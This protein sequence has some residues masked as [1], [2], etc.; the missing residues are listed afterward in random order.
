MGDI[1]VNLADKHHRSRSSHQ[2]AVSV[3]EAIEAIGRRYGA[4]TKV[5]EVPPGPPVMAPIVAEIYGP[6]EAGRIAVARGVKQVF[7]GTRD[8]VAIDDSIDEDAPKVVLHVLQAKAA[9]LGVAQSDI[10]EV[11]AMGLAGQ[12][13]TPARNTSSKFEIPV[14]VT[15][16]AEQQSGLEA[17]LKLRVMSREGQLVPVSELVEVRRVQR[18]KAVYHKDLLPVVYVYGDMG[19]KLDSPCTACSTS[20]ARWRASPWP[21]AAACPNGSSSNPLTPM[22]ATPSNGTGSGRSPTRP[23]GTWARPT[24]R[25]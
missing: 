5:V 23:S 16:P 7:E 4:S 2:V 1:Q 24:G 19:G 8:I 13:V 22:P 6:D 3:R 14:R 20:A 17:L 12:D 25:G 10:V 9:L 21:R 15:L 11:V 18:E